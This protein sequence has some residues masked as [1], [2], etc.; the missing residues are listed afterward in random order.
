[1]K[2][3]FPDINNLKEFTSTK[4]ALQRILEAILENGEKH[5]HIKRNYI[6]INTHKKRL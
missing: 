4:L 2:K 3:N 5:K 6:N 1:L